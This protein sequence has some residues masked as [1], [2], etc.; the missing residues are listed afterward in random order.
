MSK[1]PTATPVLHH[2]NLKT[3][4]LQAMIDWYGEVAGLRPRFQF[5]GGAWLSNDGA[6]HRLALLSTPSL[7]DDPGKLA[8]TGMHHFA[9]EYPDMDSLLDSYVRLRDGGIE[10]HMALDHGMTLSFYYVDPDGNSVELQC[11]IFGDWERSTHWMTTSAEFAANP[12]GAPIDGDSLV[13]ARARGASPE[14]IHRRAYAGEFPPTKP[15]D[16]RV[17]L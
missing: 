2:V 12:I 8:H 13:A 7:S 11:D 3:T 10:P 6:N 9:F 15:F 16:P 17:P 14:E 1:P 5:P 4:R